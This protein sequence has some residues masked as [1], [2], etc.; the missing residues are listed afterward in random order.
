MPDNV[1]RGHFFDD[2]LTPSEKTA[3]SKT[4]QDIPFEHQLEIM[5]A[6]L[7]KTYSS[8][9]FDTKQLIE[10]LGVGEKKIRALKRDGRLSVLP[11]TNRVSVIELAK[12]MIA[13]S[14]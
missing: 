3:I 2:L 6:T 5:V 8:I 9:T 12:F 11:N 10:I 1:Y 4:E 14:A 7:T 13:D